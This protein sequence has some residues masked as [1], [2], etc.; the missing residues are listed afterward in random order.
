[1]NIF[2]E[3]YFYGQANFGDTHKRAKSYTCTVHTP[4]L[5]KTVQTYF[6]VRHGVLLSYTVFH[7]LNVTALTRSVCCHDFDDYD[8]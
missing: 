1:M 3:V 6:F 7:T 4:C 8:L 5:K 2:I